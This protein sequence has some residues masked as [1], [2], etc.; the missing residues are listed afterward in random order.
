MEAGVT[1]SAWDDVRRAPTGRWTV[2]KFNWLAN[3]KIIQTLERARPH[4]RGVL[5]D[6]GCG[7]KPFAPLFEGRVTRYLGTDLSGSQYLGASRPDAYARAGVEHPRPF[8]K[9]AGERRHG[10][11]DFRLEVQQMAA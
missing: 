6:V 1:P 7:A 8:R 5:L 11:F 2:W 3:H 10:V 4:A 9:I